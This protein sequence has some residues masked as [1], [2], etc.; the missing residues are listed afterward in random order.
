MCPHSL[1]DTG[2]SALEANN[3]PSQGW[4]TCLFGL[5]WKTD[6]HM[7]LQFILNF[8]NVKEKI[9]KLL[10]PSHE[11][12]VGYVQISVYLVGL[13]VAINKELNWH[14]L[15]SYVKEAF[16]HH[17]CCS[18]RS[19]ATSFSSFSGINKINQLWCNL[20]LTKMPHSTHWIDF[21][22]W[23]RSFGQ[24][25]WLTEKQNETIRA[26]HILFIER[27]SLHLPS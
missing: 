14:R 25:A 9:K 19:P 4:W 26:D 5:L 2:L 11:Q 27:N 22:T 18:C 20:V 21:W 6:E 17:W 24:P 12:R 13:E 15:C 3:L 10:L 8:W 23:K 1:S 16:P 7:E